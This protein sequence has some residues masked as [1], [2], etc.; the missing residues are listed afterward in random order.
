MSHSEK[1]VRAQ[2]IGLF[3][4]RLLKCAYR[5]L[6]SALDIVD[7]SEIAINF[8]EFRVQFDNLL[9]FSGCLGIV[10]S[11]LCLLSSLEVSQDRKSTRLNS[12]HEWISYAVFCLKTKSRIM[13]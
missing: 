6:V 3:F 12:S 13:T 2:E 7:K 4:K 11:L 9:V 8:C 5:L 10:T 1:K